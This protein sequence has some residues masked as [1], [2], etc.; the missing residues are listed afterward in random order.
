MKARQARLVI[1]G[2]VFAGLLAALALALMMVE[3]DHG[4]DPFGSVPEGAVAWQMHNEETGHIDGPFA[5]PDKP[6]PNGYPVLS[7]DFYITDETVDLEY[8]FWSSAD[9]SCE[10]WHLHDSFNGH[11]DFD[12][13]GCG[14]GIIAYLFDEPDPEPEP[15]EC[16]GELV[17]IEGTDGDDVITGTADRDVIHGKAGNDQIDGLAGDDLIC[18]GPGRDRLRG[19]DGN[20]RILGNSGRDRIFGGPGDDTLDGGGHK[21]VLLGG[22][23]RDVLWGR[24]G[25]DFLVGGADGDRLF[26]GPG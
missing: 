9:E 19:G 18:G 23:G 21:D 8:G 5:L 24:T 4:A 6:N 12:S 25:D 7:P 26:A 17:T 3:A 1:V 20:D 15:L 16:L 2:G 13:G 11:P 14:H 10:S 22:P